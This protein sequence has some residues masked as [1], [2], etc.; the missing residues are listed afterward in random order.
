M[1]PS[2]DIASLT[3]EERLQLIELLWNS[4]RQ[5]PEAIG[6]T[7]AQAEELDRR[8]DEVEKGDRAGIPWNDVLRRIRERR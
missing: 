4:L 1:I 7:P 3:P 2:I 6:L 8:L 5:T